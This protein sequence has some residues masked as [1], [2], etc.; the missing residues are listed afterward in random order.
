M[1]TTLLLVL[2]FNLCQSK[3]PVCGQQRPAAGPDTT[4]WNS[5]KQISVFL[6]DYLLAPTK[7]NNF[8]AFIQYNHLYSYGDGV[9]MPRISILL[10]PAITLG[11]RLKSSD[12]LFNSFKPLQQGRVSLLPTLIVSSY[13]DNGQKKDIELFA[14]VKAGINYYPLIENT[15]TRAHGLNG[16]EQWQVGIGGGIDF[17]SIIRLEGLYYRAG[18]DLNKKTRHYFEEYIN[19]SA[20]FNAVRVTA[21]FK[22]YKGLSGVVDWHGFANS[23]NNEKYYSVALNYD[24]SIPRKK[25]GSSTPFT[26]TGEGPET[27]SRE[28]EFIP[29]TNVATRGQ[30]QS[31]KSPS[32]LVTSP[33][34]RLT[35]P[36][37]PAILPELRLSEVLHY[38]GKPTDKVELSGL[39][40]DG[41]RIYFVSDNRS[42]I[43]QIQLNRGN[44]QIIDTIVT[45]P[46]NKSNIYNFEGIAVYENTFFVIDENI[47]STVY[48]FAADGKKLNQDSYNGKI[49]YKK[50]DGL[51]GIALDPRRKVM[52]LAKERDSAIIYKVNMKQKE[53][54]SV[55]FALGDL[56]DDISD[57]QFLGNH[58]YVLERRKHRISK[59]DSTGRIVAQVSFK[60][61]TTS[62]FGSYKQMYA[63]GNG[64]EKYGF[65]EALLIIK[66]KIYVGMDSGSNKVIRP[67]FTDTFR[68]KGAKSNG[69]PTVILIFD[70]PDFF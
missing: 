7:S 37:L 14:S 41:N 22:I 19:E 3:I 48:Q 43:Y 61:T 54:L 68:S 32:T 17:K 16:Y 5:S 28:G 27:V 60:S 42:D 55:L 8:Y 30:S 26:L 33:K 51:E 67:W 34:P 69:N 53:N 12:P 70:K 21:K 20:F 56:T 24:Y 45:T 64:N 31:S 38:N 2:V 36:A 50:N 39:A 1:K 66:D 35:Q 46:K 9:K 13:I 18:Y 52:F 59:L 57:L 62:S 11:G 63:E 65:S 49:S 29:K 44:F 15:G 4:S 6:G 47:N 58:L 25:V 10:N 40:N 23:Y